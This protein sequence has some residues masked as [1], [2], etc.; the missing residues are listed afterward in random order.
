[1]SSENQVPNVFVGIDVSKDRLDVHRLPQAEAQS[2]AHERADLRALVAWLQQAPPALIV[3]EATGGLE[4]DVVA[5]LAAARLNVVVVNPRQ[6]RQFAGA[7][8]KLAKTDQIDAAVLARFAQDVRPVVRALPSEIERELAEIVARRRQLI[9]QRTAESNRLQQAASIKVQRNIEHSLKF[10]DKQI[11][12]LEDQLDKHI[13]QNAAWKEK[14]EL[15]RSVPGV[16]PA[17]SR[18]LLADLPELGQCS[19]R[20]IAGLVGVAPLNRDSGKFR[21]QRTTWGGRA[22]VR[23]TLYMATLSA[24]RYYPPLKTVYTRLKDQG[25]KSKVAIVACMRK[26]VILLNSILK[27]KTPCKYL[28]TA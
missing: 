27:T 21:G 28:Q 14:D 1:M 7:I 16:G 3:L 20:E 13:E 23:S 11:K 25:K 10:L 15:L 19:R 17:T 12:Q 18:T 26:L 9:E 4:R 2:F 24:I 22:A 8:G 5:E 6:V